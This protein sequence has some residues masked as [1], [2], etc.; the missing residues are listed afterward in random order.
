M[1]HL[2]LSEH[3]R[4]MLR[5]MDVFHPHPGHGCEQGILGLSEGLTLQKTADEFSVHL[6]QCRAVASA[7]GKLGLAGLYEGRHTG[8]RRKRTSQQQQ[9]LAELA[10]SAGGS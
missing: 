6:K 9:A 1:K 4:C 2:E 10:Q 5:E 3:E 8:R 7:L